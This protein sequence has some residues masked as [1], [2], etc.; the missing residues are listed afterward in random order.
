LALWAAVFVALLVIRLGEVAFSAWTPYVTILPA[1]ALIMAAYSVCQGDRWALPVAVGFG[2][3]VVQT[4]VGYAP[5]VALVAF[6]TIAGLVVCLARGPR[7]GWLWPSLIAGV[8]LAIVWAPPAID[9]LVHHPSNL[10]IANRFRSHPPVAPG[11]ERHDLAEGVSVATRLTG[12]VFG[13]TRSDN[14]ASVQTGLGSWVTISALLAAAAWSVYRRRWSALVMAG[15][16][17]MAWVAG[18]MA[19]REII[20][21]LFDYLVLWIAVASLTAWLAVGMAVLPELKGR[22]RTRAARVL[23]VIGLTAMLVALPGTRPSSPE[24]SGVPALARAER[25]LHR[26]EAKLPRDHRVIVVPDQDGDW[27]YVTA[28][29]AGLRADGYDVRAIQQRGAME[30]VFFP[31]DRARPRAGDLILSVGPRG[32]TSHVSQP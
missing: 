9:L 31:W 6:G 18:V 13:V 23:A 24:G 14:A 10:E 25:L 20:G 30:T 11:Y 19:V 26:A 4:H 21:P 27:P 17:V 1:V 28:L 15:F 7:A 2:S 32:A 22:G 12:A 29:V 16:A 3:F 5:L 8:L